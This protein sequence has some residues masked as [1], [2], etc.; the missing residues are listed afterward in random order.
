MPNMLFTKTS[1]HKFTT[2]DVNSSHLLSL[3][4]EASL[5]RNITDD[6]IEQLGISLVKSQP[7]EVG[8]G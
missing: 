3:C 6:T 2:I 4:T 8:L 7:R 1:H 5:V